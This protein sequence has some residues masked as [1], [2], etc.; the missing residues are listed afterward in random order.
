MEV[1][2]SGV[3][4]K[5]IVVFNEYIVPHIFANSYRDV[6]M[7]LDI[8]MLIIGCSRWICRGDLLREDCPRFWVTLL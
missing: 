1:R 4:N 7:L 6:H 2:V 5:V 3:E 8:F